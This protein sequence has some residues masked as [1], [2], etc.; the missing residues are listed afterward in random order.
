MSDEDQAPEAEA[1]ETFDEKRAKE[2]IAKANSEAANLRKR[3][4][5][6]EPLAAKAKELEDANLG[7]NEKLNKQIADLTKERD[8]ATADATRYKVALGKGLTLAQARRLSG[9]TE[10]ELTADADAYR[11]EHGLSK[12]GDKPPA[13]RKPAENLRGGGDPDDAPPVDVRKVIDTIPR[14][15]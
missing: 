5:E 10:D 11:E 14:G 1:D 12:Q 3:L 6:L 2:K 4:K 9:A 15:F 7:E 13:D 8:A